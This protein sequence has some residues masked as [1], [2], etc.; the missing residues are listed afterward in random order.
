MEGISPKRTE[1]ASRLPSEFLYLND[2]I[3]KELISFAKCKIGKI[4]YEYVEAI[5]SLR[6]ALW[7]I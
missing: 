3:I 4:S 2:K 7:P 5:H 1:S 6:H